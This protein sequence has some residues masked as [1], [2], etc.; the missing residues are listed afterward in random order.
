MPTVAIVC[1]SAPRLGDP[2]HLLVSRIKEAGHTTYLAKGYRHDAR[3]KARIRKMIGRA[4]SLVIVMT[5]ERSTLVLQAPAYTKDN[6]KIIRLVEEG[7]EDD[8]SGLEDVESLVRF[9]LDAFSGI[10]D[11]VIETLDSSKEPVPPGDA[12]SDVSMSLPDYDGFRD[13][14]RVG[15]GLSAADHVERSPMPPDLY[16]NHWVITKLGADDL[17]PRLRFGSTWAVCHQKSSAGGRTQWITAVVDT[18][19]KFILSRKVTDKAPSPRTVSLVFKVAL[20]VAGAPKVVRCDLSEDGLERLKKILKSVPSFTDEVPE[21][22]KLQDA[23]GWFEDYLEAVIKKASTHSQTP[24]S[25]G[26]EPLVDY[27]IISHNFLRQ[28]YSDDVPADLAG[29]GHTFEDIDAVLKYAMTTQKYLLVKLADVIPHITIRKHIEYDKIDIRINPGINERMKHRIVSILEELKLMHKG[30]SWFC[31]FS[32]HVERWDRSPSPYTYNLFEVC[33][34]CHTISYSTQDVL[35]HNGVRYGN[36]QT[37][38]SC[39]SCRRRKQNVQ[40]TLF[41]SGNP[42]NASATA[43]PRPRPGA[44]DGSR[45]PG[46][47]NRRLPARNA[48]RPGSVRD[49]G[50]SST[51]VLVSD[52]MPAD[53]R[54]CQAKITDYDFR[55]EP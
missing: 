5:R 27:E 32:F 31:D 29:Y 9:R 21:Y 48:H 33:N 14:M 39:K 36:T 16:K 11:H 8:S 19:T 38:P 26:I 4:D 55:V 10:I 47:Q 28:P 15:R 12:A 18:H 2:I 49:D 24:G 34:Q 46:S 20:H 7:A 35:L 37:Q 42:A 44:A 51:R 30:G 50:R 3:T 41:P 13:P 22:A 1:S 53:E 23:D 6:A 54:S 25:C 17:S 45:H 40:T 43:S 52:D